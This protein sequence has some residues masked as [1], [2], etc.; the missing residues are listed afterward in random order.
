MCLNQHVKLGTLPHTPTA[1]LK[2]DQHWLWGSQLWWRR[3]FRSR[4]HFCS[5]FSLLL[6]LFASLL[7]DL[8]SISGSTRQVQVLRFHHRHPL[9]TTRP[10]L[11][12]DTFRSCRLDW[13]PAPGLQPTVDLVSWC[14]NHGR[15]FGKSGCIVILNREGVLWRQPVS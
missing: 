8:L 11:P 13:A 14:S 6:P 3:S 10:G 15:A 2:G 1:W 9:G 12:S 5:C 7:S 4:S